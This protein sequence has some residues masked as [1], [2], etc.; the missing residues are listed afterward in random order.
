MWPEVTGYRGHALPDVAH[1][2]R[3]EEN[4]SD[5]AGGDESLTAI[6]DLAGLAGNAAR[7]YLLLAVIFLVTALTLG[8][9]L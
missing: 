9:F 8:A 5:A 7:L 4:L 2:G 1:A 3:F 6:A